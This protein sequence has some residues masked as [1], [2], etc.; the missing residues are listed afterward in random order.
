MTPR[1]CTTAPRSCGNSTSRVSGSNENWGTLMR[2]DPATAA[3]WDQGRSLPEPGEHAKLDELLTAKHLT[4]AALARTGCRITDIDVLM[5]AWPGGAKFRN[6]S[7][8]RRWNSLDP[9]FQRCHII[10]PSEP[11][12]E[13]P[14]VLLIGEGETDSARLSLLYPRA[15]VAILP[16]GADFVP[17][18]LPEQAA[19]YDRVYACHDADKAGEQGAEACRA[20]MPQ[21]VRLAPPEG[22]VDWCEL[23]ADAEAPPLP[24][25][26]DAAGSII[27]EGF[28]DMLRDGVPEPIQL[29][30][31]VLYAEGVHW[32]D[33][34][35]GCGKTTL[36]AHWSVGLMHERHHIVWLDYEGG[37]GPTVR[38]FVAAGLDYETAAEY[39]H[40]A[41]W[42]VD[43][44][45]SLEAVAR[46]WPGALVV[47]DSA[48]KALSAA[49]RDENSNTEVTQWTV[50]LVQAAKQHHLPL[51]IIDHVTKA[52]TKGSIWARGAGA[53][54][55]DSDVHWRVETH[56]AFDRQTVGI[57]GLRRAKDREGFFPAAHWFNVG[58]GQGG[59][60]V[61]PC[62]EPPEKLAPDTESF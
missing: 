37:I 54:K 33:G 21:C 43:A 7:T 28:A 8:G 47:Y 10:T 62:E 6:L 12:A 26:P 17:M 40:Y 25:P 50:Q 41:G 36:A 60:P 32:L 51:V 52:T 45:A 13:Q 55:A 27:F 20:A 42:P 31:D 14:S 30:P 5:W 58:D 2:E 53:K 24:A 9:R 49:G 35:P 19:T 23:P 61:V 46:R 57:V 18:K 44:E 39:M 1:S 38:R 4:R 34:E 56:T 59:L 16:L 29:V 48:S 15:A 11:D 22:F 3:L